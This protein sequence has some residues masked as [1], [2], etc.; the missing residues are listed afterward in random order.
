[1][2]LTWCSRTSR[3]KGRELQMLKKTLHIQLESG[4]LSSM[5]F[6]KSLFNRRNNNASYSQGLTTPS[7]RTTSRKAAIHNIDAPIISSLNPS[8]SLEALKWKSILRLA[9]TRDKFVAAKSS[10]FRNPRITMKPA[11]VSVKWWM[12][13]AFVIESSLVSSLDELM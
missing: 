4:K 6:S 7:G 3:T 13:G 2:L 12:T 5:M 11:I 8:H 9:L 1:M 10:C